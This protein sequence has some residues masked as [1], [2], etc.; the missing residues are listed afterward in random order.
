M[1]ACCVGTVLLIPLT[2]IFM[3]TFDLGLNG[4]PLAQAVQASTILGITTV[5]CHCKPE[6]RSVMQP[7][8]C[9]ALFGWK[10]YL[11]V[12]LPATVMMCAE[13][14][15]FDVLTF[16]AGILG[17]LELASQT[18]CIQLVILLCMVPTGLQEAISAL[19]GNSIGANNVPLAERFFSLTFKITLL[20][21]II[22]ATVTILAR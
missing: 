19:I 4:I 3:F 9:E 20:I 13:W 6:I 16:L 14:W 5:Y 10:E 2:Y 21:V 1:I 18:I 22:M 15:A 17:V 11:K 12:S 7:Y 8:S